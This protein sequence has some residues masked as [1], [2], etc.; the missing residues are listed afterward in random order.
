MRADRGY[1][2]AKQG[3]G[4]LYLELTRERQPNVDPGLQVRRPK[5]STV[6]TVAVSP[7]PLVDRAH[8]AEYVAALTAELAILVRR[9]QLHT[10]GYLL[11]LARLEAEEVVQKGEGAAPPPDPKA[12]QPSGQRK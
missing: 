11:D 5:P 8:A 6:G 7:V 1:L 3:M 9:H 2:P 12:S 10:L 4:Y